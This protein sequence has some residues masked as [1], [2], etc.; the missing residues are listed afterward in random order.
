VQG[1]ETT[2]EFTTKT[3]KIRKKFPDI[4]SVLRE[5]MSSRLI[6]RVGKGG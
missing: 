3:V 5:R 1:V 2:D 4:F 6:R